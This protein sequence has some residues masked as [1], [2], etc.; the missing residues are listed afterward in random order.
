M[1]I[2]KYDDIKKMLID[3]N[4][5]TLETTFIFGQPDKNSEVQMRDK[6]MT[7]F[8][9]TPNYPQNYGKNLDLTMHF[10]VIYNL[11]T[12]FILNYY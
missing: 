9:Q 10:K 1:V 12:Y 3:I 5:L 8:L 4:S 2:N 6:R 7:F 11:S